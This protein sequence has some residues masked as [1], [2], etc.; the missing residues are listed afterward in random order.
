MRDLVNKELVDPAVSQAEREEDERLMKIA[1]DFVQKEVMP[2]VLERLGA[3]A[4]D[5]ELERVS[6]LLE[7]QTSPKTQRLGQRS[8]ADI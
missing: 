1:Q 6:D 2:G 7:G 3:D 4:Q 5:A 8:G